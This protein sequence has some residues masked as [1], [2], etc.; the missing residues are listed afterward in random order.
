MEMDV[1]PAASSVAADNNRDCQVIAAKKKDE[2]GQPK[3]R[4]I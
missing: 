4:A 3:G 2:D 1:N